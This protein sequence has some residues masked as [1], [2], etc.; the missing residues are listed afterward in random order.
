M[1]GL[2]GQPNIANI[3][4]W[5]VVFGTH[6]EALG[7]MGEELSLNWPSAGSRGQFLNFYPFL[8]WAPY[9]IWRLGHNG[10]ALF[11]PVHIK[12]DSSDAI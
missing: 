8:F 3:A 2:C 7:R 9:G 11:M 4:P 6:M 5:H 1:S 10:R 12:K